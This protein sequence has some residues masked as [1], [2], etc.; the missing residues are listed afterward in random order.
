MKTLDNDWKNFELPESKKI[1]DLS[2][3]MR[4]KYALVHGDENTEI[5]LLFWHYYRGTNTEHKPEG[6]GLWLTITKSIIEL[7]RGTISVSSIPGIGTVFQIQF[8]I[9]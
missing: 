9:N 1:K 5:D 7:H 3:G 2:R 6:T 4:M 8:P